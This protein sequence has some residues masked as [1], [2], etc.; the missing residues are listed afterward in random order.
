[1]SVEAA[2]NWFSGHQ[3][4]IPA[5]D[6]FHDRVTELLNQEVTTLAEIASVIMFDPGMSTLLLR[7]VNTKLKTNGRA[8]IDTLHTAV[9]HLGKPAIAKLI[10]RHKKIGEVCSHKAAINSYRQLLSE[11][12]HALVQLD[13]FASMQG[14]SNVEDMR[15]A[16]L[17]Y[18]LGAQ[19]ACLFDPDKYQEYLNRLK[20]DGQSKNLAADIFGFDFIQ[21]GK[22]LAQEWAL[23]E[24]VVESLESTINSGRKSRL[25][26][27]AANIAH[28]AERGWYHKA[29]YN[30]QKKCADYLNISLEEA[31][32]SIQNTAIKAARSSP[33]DDVFYAAA[34]LIL[35][36]D[37]KQVS[38]PNP[39][40]NAPENVKATQHL[41][42]A[43]QIKLLLQTR[44]VNQSNIL[45]SL[46]IDLQ[47]N[48]NFSRVVLMLL[49]NDKTNLKTRSTKGLEADSTFNQ[50]ELE[51]AQSGLIKS[52]LQKPHAVRIDPANYKKYQ[53]MLPGKFQAVCQCNN[54]AV[55]S[56]FIGNKPIGLVYCDRH[57]I[58]KP[59]DNASYQAFK[60]SVMIASKAL[61]YLAK[62]KARAAA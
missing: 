4:F 29:M 34:Q 11:G 62:L 60:S 43:E 37:I 19:H 30:A 22:L 33:I 12:C 28:Q 51:V 57:Q 18:N 39:V 24:L 7:Q 44:E 61:T 38:I 36:P 9:G 40:S 41:S 25:I 49:S 8:G 42:L 15:T 56:I 32:R 17:L 54:F 5:L 50:L 35:M 31:R 47:K 20:V 53:A 45:N 46:L 10:A 59:I 52:L 55:M 16:T 26:Q 3:E 2:Q 13:G 27:L 14:I 21:L 58:E 1:M 6:H 23:P 48:L